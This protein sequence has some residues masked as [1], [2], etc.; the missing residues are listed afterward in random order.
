[1]QIIYSRDK[2]HH[3]GKDCLI[4]RSELYVTSKTQ[5]KNWHCKH[6]IY[7]SWQHLE[8]F[9]GSMGRTMQSPGENGLMLLIII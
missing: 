2:T 6:C 9:A 1:M 7:P 8:S 3:K 5:N 4:H